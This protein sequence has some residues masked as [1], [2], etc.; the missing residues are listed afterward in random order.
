MRSWE[1]LLDS[2]SRGLGLVQC[3]VIALCSW[4]TLTTTLFT[5]NNLNG[6]WQT[7]QEMGQNAG[8]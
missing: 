7:F 8:R 6:Y 5:H 3:M 1:I 4:E 2:G